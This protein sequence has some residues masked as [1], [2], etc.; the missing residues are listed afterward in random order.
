MLR[1]LLLFTVTAVMFVLRQVKGGNSEFVF[2]SLVG[3]GHRRP[4]LIN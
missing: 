4:D 2:F 1:F 3:G